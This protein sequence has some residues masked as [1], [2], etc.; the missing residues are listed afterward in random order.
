MEQ[1]IRGF[2]PWEAIA[3]KYFAEPQVDDINKPVESAEPSKAVTFGD[4]DSESG[5]DEEDEE[6]KPKLTL[7]EEDAA[8]DFENLD[9][10]PPTEV[11]NQE[12]PKANDP[13]DEINS[14]A[15]ETLVLNL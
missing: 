1:V 8:I 5:S 6:E 12:T 4:S 9:E 7:S 13:M 3:K 10:P 15:Q 2:L 14:K 11:K